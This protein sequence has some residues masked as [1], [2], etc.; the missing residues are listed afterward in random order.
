MSRRRFALM[1]LLALLGLGVVSAIGPGYASAR[2]LKVNA[3]NDTITC[4]GQTGS[5]TVT[6]PLRNP[7]TLSGKVKMSIAATLTGCTVTPAPGGTPVSVSQGVVSGTLTGSHGTS[8]YSSIESGGNL[9][10]KGSL[11]IEWT[12]S[13]KLKSPTTKIQIKSAT[14]GLLR[15]DNPNDI[16]NT[17]TFPGD[18]ASHVT[19]SFSADQAASFSYSVTSETIEDF[20]VACESASGL[21]TMTESGGFTDFGVP[22]RISVTPSDASSIAIGDIAPAY[23]ATATYPG[24]FSLDV[25]STAAW[26]SSDHSVATF[27]ASNGG[28]LATTSPLLNLLAPG[29][30]E[31]SASLGGADE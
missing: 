28:F 1:L 26:S 21:S 16:V 10:F 19:G 13:P 9:P 27:V 6:P 7:G 4:T 11:K 22:P 17:L 30:T 25:S 24:N 15:G 2:T 29:T 23:D 20:T 31:I 14:L 3:S 5:T 8:C 18:T 12:S